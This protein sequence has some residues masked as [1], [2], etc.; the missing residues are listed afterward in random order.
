MA[1]DDRYIVNTSDTTQNI[2]P[3]FGFHFDFETRTSVEDIG[4]RITLTPQGN[5]KIEV[6]QSAPNYYFKTVGYRYTYYRTKAPT[7]RKLE[8]ENRFQELLRQ[9]GE[10][11]E[12]TKYV[13]P[14]V[15]IYQQQFP[16]SPT[17]K[18]PKTGI[19]IFLAIL[20][21][22]GAAAIN[23][24]GNLVFEEEIMALVP[25]FLRSL[26]LGPTQ[27]LYGPMMLLGGLAVFLVVIS[28]IKR[29]KYRNYVNAFKSRSYDELE[30]H[31]KKQVKENL[32]SYAKYIS[33]YKGEM[34]D[35]VLEM[36]EINNQYHP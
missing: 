25:E 7:G 29:T 14:Y 15:S 5:G 33:G 9:K 18:A 19:L 36:L 35:I 27:I 32:M 1:F 21:I 22:F 20:L 10:L 26:D 17:R 30:P 34:L 24:L 28:I 13:P 2:L 3:L 11:V 31:E 8:L 12:Y 16:L 4:S 23:L 6:S